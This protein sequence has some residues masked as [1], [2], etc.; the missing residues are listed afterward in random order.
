MP[1]PPLT[2]EWA[3]PSVADP[4]VLPFDPSGPARVLHVINGEHY[5]G[6]E[7]VQDLL[8]IR[9]P[10]CGYEVGIAALKPGKFE[11]VRLSVGTPLYN[12]HM[13]GRFDLRAVREVMRIARDGDYQLLHAH[14]PRT[15]MVTA[16]ASRWSGLPWVYHVHSPVSLDSGRLLQN[17]V[18][19]F[20][21]R[22]S[23]RSAA[24]AVVV[25]PTLLSYMQGLHFRADR[26]TCVP[27]GVPLSP[28][29]RPPGPISE[30]LTLGMVALFRPR[31]GMEVLLESLAALVSRGHQVRF[32]AIGGFET[33]EYENE[34]H[35]LVT[36]LDLAD[37]IDFTGFTTDVAKE[38]LRLDALVLPSLYGEGL[39][40]VVLEAMASGVPV[41]ASHVEGVSTAIEHRQS[42]LLVEPG[43]VSQLALAIEQLLTGEVDP[44]KL[45]AAALD[46]HR[47]H[48]SDLA[49]ARGVAEVYSSV[50]VQT[51]R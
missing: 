2:T 40:M 25:S 26:L 33:P 47:N 24:A 15:A 5:S 4:I 29:V 3:D 10:E 45:A 17:R 6:A 51:A 18:N 11:E 12:I 49:M 36:R 43:S 27:N 50:L 7:R 20:V 35:Q 37:H 9:L 32:H 34:I 22:W 31:K 19:T 21:E 42:G 13:R 48:F 23:L 28:S 1:A 30:P 39:P 14:T 44:D 38:L 8:A 16:I 46:R 41:V